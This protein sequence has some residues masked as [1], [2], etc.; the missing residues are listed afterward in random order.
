[1]L[2]FQILH[3]LGGRTFWIHNTGPLG[4][5]PIILT[6]APVADNQLDGAGC[7]KR[8]NDLAQYFN[9]LLKK[10]V[11]QLRKDLPLAAFTYVDVYSAKYS[12][13]QQPKNYGK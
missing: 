1:M 7:A 12:L 2:Y 8:Y 5:L 6:V 11:D 3:S 9:N 13:Y 4:C 10:G